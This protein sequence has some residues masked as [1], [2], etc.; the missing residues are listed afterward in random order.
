[1]NWNIIEG[2]WKEAA[3]SAHEQW[4]KITHD[5]LEEVSGKKDK[6]EGLVQQR[7]GLTQD[8]AARQVD[9][10]ADKLKNTFNK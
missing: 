7:Y 6:L 5:E 8:A 9:E 4:G 2:M 10:W 1:M 3:G